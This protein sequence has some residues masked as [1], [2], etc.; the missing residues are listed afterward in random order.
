MPR[1]AKKKRRDD[2]RHVVLRV[3]VQS[4]YGSGF[5]VNG[6][7]RIVAVAGAPRR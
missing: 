6:I 7:V 2:P 3:Y 5:N 1:E 4:R